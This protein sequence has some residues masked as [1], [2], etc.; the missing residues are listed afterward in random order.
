MTTHYIA[1][2]WQAGEGDALESR[3]HVGQAVLWQGAAA[4]PAQV[5]AAVQA[6][7]KAETVATRD[8]SITR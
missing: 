3:N 2:A 4:S 8:R 1:G 5:D 6:H 7:S